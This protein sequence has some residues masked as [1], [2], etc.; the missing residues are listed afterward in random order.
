M[1]PG[2][3]LSA[4]NQERNAQHTVLQRTS[5]RTAWLNNSAIYSPSHTFHLLK[6][7]AVEVGWPPRPNWRT[8]WVSTSSSSGSLCRAL[9]C[10]AGPIFSGNPRPP[11]RPPSLPPLGACTPDPASQSWREAVGWE[12]PGGVRGRGCARFPAPRPPSPAQDQ[13]LA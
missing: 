2:H 11:M 9:G 5:L 1:R 6:G 12:G 8:H 3:P 10:R 7:V 13:W 4:A